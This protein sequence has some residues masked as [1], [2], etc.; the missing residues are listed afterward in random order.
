[1]PKK[2]PN[3]VFKV[4]QKMVELF[5]KKEAIVWPR[6]LKITEQLIKKYPEP[7]FWLHMDLGFQLNSLA[8]FIGS[9]GAA[10]IMR[11]YK[12]YKFDLPIKE[13]YNIG[14]EK[15]GEDK[16]IEKRQGS[17]KEFLKLWK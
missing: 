2:P 1:M 7:D 10:E 9:E 12:L 17:I 16:K 15:V 13:E 8:W 6:E 11:R 14:K 3:P 4:R 5:V